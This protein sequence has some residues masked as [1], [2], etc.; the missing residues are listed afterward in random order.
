MGTRSI[1]RKLEALKKRIEAEKA[2][3]AVTPHAPTK[4]LTD[5]LS[6]PRFDP[7]KPKV[8]VP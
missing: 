2:R 4:G 8:T 3:K 6:T 7:A 5:P 1:D